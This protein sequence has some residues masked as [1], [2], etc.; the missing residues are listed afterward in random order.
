ML[1]VAGL[2]Y[3][4]MPAGDYVQDPPVGFWPEYLRAIV[5]RINKQY[6][7]NIKIKWNLFSDSSKI[8]DSV[9]K[10][11]SDMTDLYM[12]LS[13]FY[14]G[15]DRIEAFSVSCSP[16]GYESTVTV[17]R[18]SGMESMVDLN[19]ALES[20]SVV[21]VGA[22]SS[23]DFNAVKPFMS[24]KAVPTYFESVTDMRTNMLNGEILAGITSTNP[25]ETDDF[26]TFRSGVVSPRAVMMLNDMDEV[27]E[28]ENKKDM[29]GIWITLGCVG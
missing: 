11:E 4:D 29:T 27:L 3:I 16:G 17:L 26:A 24:S 20:G 2:R 22:L 5:A 12:I 10:G 8:M 13:S 28:P 1:T 6:G 18:S 15:K 23:A 25:G 14:N 21:K 19:N 7:V 9:R